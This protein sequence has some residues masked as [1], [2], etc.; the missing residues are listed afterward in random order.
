MAALSA[1]DVV[2]ITGNE[3]TECIRASDAL[4]DELVLR[5]TLGGAGDDGIEV[6][7]GVDVWTMGNTGTIAEADIVDTIVGATTSSVDDS[8]D[9]VTWAV[10]TA[11]SRDVAITT[12]SDGVTAAGKVCRSGTGGA[13]EPNDTF[14]ISGDTVG[15]TIGSTGKG[16]DVDDEV[17]V[18]GVEKVVAGAGV[19]GEGRVTDCAGV[20]WKGQ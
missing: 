7:V 18:M 9:E 5:D 12:G 2:G 1:T 20:A 3:R 10:T 8:D 19:D 6:K 11:A 13:L 17:V 14:W 15:T 16:R 4:W